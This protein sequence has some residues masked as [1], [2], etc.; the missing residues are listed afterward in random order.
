[1]KKI[2]REIIGHFEVG[3]GDIDGFWE[4]LKGLQIPI[5]K[6][7]GKFALKDVVILIGDDVLSAMEDSGRQVGELEH[8]RE[9]YL[10]LPKEIGSLSLFDRD[11]Y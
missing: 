4:H 1:V 9:G 5:D 3:S 2:D 6:L 8:F 10:T 7:F 11:S